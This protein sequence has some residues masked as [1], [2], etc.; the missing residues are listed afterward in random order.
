MFA[1]PA[2]GK[3]LIASADLCC[4][5]CLWQNLQSS[6]ESETVWEVTLLLA[7]RAGFWPAWASCMKSCLERPAG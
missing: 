2:V 4:S 1:E 5:T 7:A 3:A 6:Q